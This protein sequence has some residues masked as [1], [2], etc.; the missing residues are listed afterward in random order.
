M[1]YSLKNRDEQDFFISCYKI[2]IHEPESSEYKIS[3][4]KL[5]RL[6]EILDNQTIER[7]TQSVVWILRENKYA[8]LQGMQK[9]NAGN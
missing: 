7:I 6:S 3:K 2:L 8:N 1:L 5:E 9:G 4:C